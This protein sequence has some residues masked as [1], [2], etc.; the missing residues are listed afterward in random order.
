[1][2]ILYNTNNLFVCIHFYVLFMSFIFQP[3][4][5]LTYNFHT[6]APS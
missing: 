5:K 4:E 6:S 2:T 3:E 1:M